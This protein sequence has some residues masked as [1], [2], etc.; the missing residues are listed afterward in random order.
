MADKVKGTTDVNKDGNVDKLDDLNGDGRA[1]QKDVELR[2]DNLSMQ[3]LG[4]DYDFAF[5]I[6]SANPELQE[7]FKSAV[8]Q[9]L[10]KEAFEA[11]I[12][13][14]DWYESIG[15]E[16]ARKAW[17]AK[18]MG[19]ADWDD[20]MAQARDAIQRQAN[21]SGARIDPA[22]LDQ[23]AERYLFE[24]WFAQG[25]QG[26]MLDAIS[27]KVQSDQGGQIAIRDALS[28]LARDNGVGVTDQWFNEVS[29]AITRGDSTQADYEMWIRE[30]A[31]KKYPMF[32][33]K[34]KAGISVRSLASP[35]TTRMAEILELNE[36]D[37]S[38]D[39]PYIAEALGGV[40]ENGN[41]KSMNFTDFETKLRNDPRWENT[42]NGKNTLLNTAQS[43]MRDWGFIK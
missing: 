19:G 22:E 26:L 27:A 38:L 35:Y 16:Y 13:G 29:Q 9:G 39:D 5:R 14:T 42:K 31:A 15:G 41:F 40:D 33:D 8:D 1:N 28:K 17:F 32:A 34:I 37:I 18:T 6:L 20:Q 3:I 4:R 12:K 36:A 24:G 10:S 11:S 21:A 7:I 2:Q 25:R 30:Q 23:W 43:F